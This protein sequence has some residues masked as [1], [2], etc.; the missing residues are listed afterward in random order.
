[1]TRIEPYQLAYVA[2]F[3]D[4]E[5]CFSIGLN[6]S[7]SLRIVNT[8]KCTLDYV[9]RILGT[10]VIQDRVQKVN[11]RQYVYCAY[12]EN[13]MHIVD[14]LLPYLIE[15]KEQALLLIE[16]RKQDRTIRKKGSKGAFTNPARAGYIT[17]MKELKKHEQ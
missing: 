13:C 2:G 10:G 6:S 15:K 7:V 11:K 9:L 14:M 5:G 16:F 8:S 17:K 12:G 1:M 3:V 4:G